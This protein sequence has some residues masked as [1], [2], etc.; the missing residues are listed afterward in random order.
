MLSGTPLELGREAL[1]PAEQGDVI[2]LDA[3][4]GEHELQIA[5]ADREPEVPAHGPEDHLGGKAEA[6]ESRS[7]AHARRS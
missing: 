1:D 5:V 4:V 2:D 3:T 6:A 7:R